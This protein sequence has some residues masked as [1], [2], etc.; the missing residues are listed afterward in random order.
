MEMMLLS[1]S[2]RAGPRFLALCATVG[3]A[4]SIFSSSLSKSIV[5]G[6]LH[7]NRSTHYIVEDVDAIRQSLNFIFTEFLGR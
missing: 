3:G 7:N 4:F 2:F 5:I 6:F 1:A